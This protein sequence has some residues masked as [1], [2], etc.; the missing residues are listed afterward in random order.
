MSITVKELADQ[1]HL[2]I[3]VLAGRGGLERA[4]TWAHSSDLAQPWDWLSGGE[5]LMKNGHTFPRRSEAQVSFLEGLNGSGAS[6]LIIGADPHTPS[7]SRQ[8]LAS[9]DRLGLPLLRVPYSMSFIVISRAVADASVSEATG[10]VARTSRIYASIHAA[11]AGGTSRDFMERL[12]AELGCRLYVLDKETARPVLRGVSL[13]NEM[14]RGDL[15][16]LLAR[17]K[18]TVPSHLRIGEEGGRTTIAVEVPYEE[19]TLLIAEFPD[20]RSYDA[21]L[22]QHAATAAAVE[23]AHASLRQDHQRQIGSELL[24]D[25]LDVR[26]DAPTAER[27]LQEHHID[28]LSARL[29]ATRKSHAEGQR[30]LHTGLIRREIGHLL[31]R[32]D[33][34]FF[35]L[36]DSDGPRELAI[37]TVKLR[38]GSNAIIGVSHPLG[39]PLRLPDATREAMWAMALAERSSDGIAY[40]G[41]S[42]PLT[43][44]KDPA[45]AEALVERTLGPLVDYDR[46]NGTDLLGSLSTF[47]RCRRSW[48]LT[49][50]A[51][52]VHRQ[53]VVYRMER[54]EQLTGRTL[55]ETSDLAELWIALGA[56]EILTGSATP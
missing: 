48:Q 40:Y 10:L 56:L 9:A 28:P 31:L 12:E 44:L 50:Q 23:V 2:R 43:V 46:E 38:L 18:G 21:T 11:V 4:V 25:L 55:S 35:V 5:I 29:L 6:A 54:V 27:R 15:L 39:R 52:Q 33:P 16:D 34:V 24:A 32:R 7:L 37:E 8:A 53:T 14:L 13:P 20:V 47:L 26:L 1:P 22:L 3:E 17:R 41:D 42:S 45:E 30:R 19:P 36:L 49:A 51:L